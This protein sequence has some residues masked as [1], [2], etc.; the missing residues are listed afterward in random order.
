MRRL[1]ET[2]WQRRERKRRKRMRLHGR[3][4]GEVYQD[5]VNKRAG[6]RRRAP[7]NGRPPRQ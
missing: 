6:N 2:K 1:N 4:L 7:R 5:A 3:Q